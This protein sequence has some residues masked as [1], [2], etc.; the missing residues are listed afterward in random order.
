MLFS[1][2][3]IAQQVSLILGAIALVVE[4][5]QIETVP[6]G[7]RAWYVE[8]DGKFHLDPAKVEIE[9]VTGLKSALTK[10]RDAAAKAEKAR[11]KLEDDY[12]DIDPV[13]VREMLAN[14]ETDEEGKLIKAGKL[15]EVVSKRTEKL[16][17]D[18][19][20]K[21]IAAGEREK[22]AIER[23]KKFSQRVLDNHIRQAAVKSGLHAHAV[24]DA[25]FRARSMFSL[26]DDGEAV[27]LDS[28]GKVVMGKDAKTPFSPAEWLE[29]MKE[30]APHWF[31]AG[32]SGGGSRGDGGN[33]SAKT[34]KRAAFE[35]KSE[36]D[37]R[38]FLKEGGKVVD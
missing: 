20:A 2:R 12:R 32:S 4:K 5:A 6:E 25:L 33:N 30:T 34:V 16:R 3:V 31:P 29:G 18:L 19:E 27:Q 8:K 38:A 22:A 17:K 15:E 26:T 37:K 23:S 10:E 28:E 13:K 36:V 1:R 14:L 35:A 21:V 9:D 11:K 24:D 7:Q